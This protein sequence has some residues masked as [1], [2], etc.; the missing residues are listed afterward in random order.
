MWVELPVGVP[1]E[2][3][4][5]IDRL[6]D[7]VAVL[8]VEWDFVLKQEPVGVCVGVG[9]AV[10]VAGRVGGEGVRVGVGVTKGVEVTLCEGE[11][12][13]VTLCVP[14]NVT[15]PE[16]VGVPDCAGVRLGLRLRVAVGGVA[17]AERL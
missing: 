10:A 5:A 1:L 8:V 6:R 12:A 3:R 14:E 17:E 15:V 9:L 13:A 7:H 16:A 2:D 4:D 11:Q